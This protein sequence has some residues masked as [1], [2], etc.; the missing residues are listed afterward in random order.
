MF[1]ASVLSVLNDDM[2]A[3]VLPSVK[4]LN[5]LLVDISFNCV[6]FFIILFLPFNVPQLILDIQTT[7]SYIPFKQ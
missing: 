5:S 7:A 6:F 2:I 1:S 3:S 4:W